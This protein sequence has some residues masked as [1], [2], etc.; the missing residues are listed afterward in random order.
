MTDLPTNKGIRIIDIEVTSIFKAGFGYTLS[1]N[2][3][4]MKYAIDIRTNE[5]REV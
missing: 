1:R 3:L 5:K 4:A 2:M